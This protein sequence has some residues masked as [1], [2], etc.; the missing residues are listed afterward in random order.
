ML[1]FGVGGVKPN[2]RKTSIVLHFLLYLSLGLFNLYTHLTCFGTFSTL[3]F[4][5]HPIM[6][7]VCQV[8]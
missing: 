4:Y 3:G 8:L 2:Y 6:I 1:V 5:I 7:H